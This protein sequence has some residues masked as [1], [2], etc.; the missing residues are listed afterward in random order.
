MGAA[1]AE[2]DMAVAAVAAVLAEADVPAEAAVAA[3]VA[4]AAAAAVVASTAA[5]TTPASTIAAEPAR[6]HAADLVL[7]GHMLSLRLVRDGVCSLES[8]FSRVWRDCVV[9]VAAASR[10]EW[11]MGMCAEITG[12]LESAAGNSFRNTV[13]RISHWIVDEHDGAMWKLI[14]PG[15]GGEGIG[16]VDVKPEDIKATA[17]AGAI[18]SLWRTIPLAPSPYTAVREVGLEL[19]KVGA[20][21]PL[22]VTVLSGLTRTPN[23][24]PT[25]TAE[26][27]LNPYPSLN[28]TRRN[29]ARIQTLTLTVTRCSPASS[30]RARRPCSTTCSTTARACASHPG[31]R[32]RGHSTESH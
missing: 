11:Q 10:T 17:R 19:R 9:P 28:P 22:P 30:A 1:S 32:V 13:G 23:P 2:A 18:L 26:P 14:I 5:S 25:L 8:G 7:L 20:A 31:V 12:D 16:A 29:L 27:Q 24:N 21:G 4:T 6:A 3:V 15:P